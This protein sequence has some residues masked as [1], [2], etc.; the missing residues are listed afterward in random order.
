L[1]FT[2]SCLGE[3]D[4]ALNDGSTD[5]STYVSGAYNPLI[6]DTNP[7]VSEVEIEFI[8]CFPARNIIDKDT[9]AMSLLASMHTG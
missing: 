7:M 9:A 2:Q 3:T 4:L 8:D 1:Y 5:G 6:D